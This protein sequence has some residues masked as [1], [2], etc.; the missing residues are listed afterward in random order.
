M[1]GL[2]LEKDRRDAGNNSQDSKQFISLA[3]Y[4]VML[5]PEYKPFIQNEIEKYYLNHPEKNSNIVWNLSLSGKHI[6]G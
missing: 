4:D 5:N 1:A 3:S 2:H 6:S